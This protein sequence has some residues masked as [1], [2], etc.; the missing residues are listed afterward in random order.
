MNYIAPTSRGINLDTIILQD[1]IIIGDYTI[2]YGNVMIE[3]YSVIGSHCSIGEGTTQD[4][5]IIRKNTTIGSHVIIEDGLFVQGKVPSFTRLSPRDSK[6]KMW[7]RKKR[8]GYIY[9]KIRD[10]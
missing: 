10:I 1:N 7:W 6:L 2:V 4:G 3:E 8:Y 9:T 5:T